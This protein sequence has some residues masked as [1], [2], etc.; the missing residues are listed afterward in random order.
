M[1]ETLENNDFLAISCSLA[2]SIFS[3]RTKIATFGHIYNVKSNKND[4][5]NY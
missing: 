1:L 4:I 2:Q 3:D 5:L